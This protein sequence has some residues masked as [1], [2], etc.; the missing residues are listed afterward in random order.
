MASLFSDQK[1]FVDRPTKYAP[2]RVLSSFAE[3]MNAADNDP[4]RLTEGQLLDFVQQ[5]FDVEGQELEAV[6]LPDFVDE[7]SFLNG[8]KD[9]LIRAFSKKIHGFWP[10]LAR[11][12][13]NTGRC[14][15][16]ECESTLVPLKH[17]FIIPGGR[18]R[19]QCEYHSLHSLLSSTHNFNLCS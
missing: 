15:T 10:Q 19:E 1:T 9:P 7:P 3:L 16:D 12:L 11:K 17:M 14:G 5:N 18:F 6:E 13:K 2:R 8:V 4:S